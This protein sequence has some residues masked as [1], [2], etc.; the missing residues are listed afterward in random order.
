M[1]IVGIVIGVVGS[2]LFYVTLKMLININSKYEKYNVAQQIKWTT[3][4]PIENINSIEVAVVNF[5]K[6]LYLKRKNNNYKQNYD[7]VNKVNDPRYRPELEK[8]YNQYINMLLNKA[9]T[10]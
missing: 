6:V 1:L 10:L 4:K 5:R 3:L 9:K 7:Y 2:L 8:I